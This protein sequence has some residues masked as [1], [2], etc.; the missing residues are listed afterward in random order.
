MGYAA[1]AAEIIAPALSYWESIRG[2]RAMP[3]RS[4]IDPAQIPRLLPFVMLVDVLVDPLDFRFRLVG[5]EID[6]ITT[7]GLRG[8]RFSENPRLA[9]NSNIW[10]DYAAVIATRQP[11]T[12]PVDYIGT[13]RFVRDVR[14][15]LMPLSENG[16]TVSMLFV[17]VEVVRTPEL[18][19]AAPRAH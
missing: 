16:E 1:L 11:R 8:Q 10:N 13:D 3:R 7:S 6:A 19:R 4:D 12:G 2:G 9:R 17:A 14:H 15:C 5:T 18:R